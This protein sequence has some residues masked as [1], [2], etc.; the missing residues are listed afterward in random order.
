MTTS[1]KL[2]ASEF[3]QFVDYVH[4][5]KVLPD[6]SSMNGNMGLFHQ[7]VIQLAE[8]FE[9]LE[10]EGFVNGLEALQRTH[11]D[12]NIALSMSDKAESEDEAPYQLHRLDHFKNLP[13]RK[14]GVDGIIRDKGS[15]VFFGDGGSGKSG[16][17]LSMMMCKA[18]GIDWIGGRQTE[19]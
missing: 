2:G 4:T 15:S 18:Y 8:Q 16:V 1:P 10:Y 3:K 6:I 5:H 9:E 11:L 7:W 13:K 12:I 17:V 14:W 19:K